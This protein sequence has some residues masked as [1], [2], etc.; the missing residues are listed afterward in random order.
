MY[1]I[2]LL[3]LSYFKDP[4][5]VATF[6]LSKVSLFARKQ[7]QQLFILFYRICIGIFYCIVNKI[8]FSLQMF[9]FQASC[10]I[11]IFK[12]TVS[13]QRKLLFFI[14]DLNLFM[15]VFIC[16]SFVLLISVYSK[17][18][19]RKTSENDLSNDLTDTDL[20][21]RILGIVIFL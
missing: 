10:L 1:H 16:C 20:H 5:T 8:L 7:F 11:R 2:T 12:I 15:S 17:L 18:C 3:L 13:M 19:F 9:L 21:I 14:D 4:L 6:R